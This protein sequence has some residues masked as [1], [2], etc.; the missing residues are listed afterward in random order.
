MKII[1]LVYSIFLILVASRP[2]QADLV[3][4]KVERTIELTSNVA[5]I[6]HVISVENKAASAVKSYLFVVEPEHAKILAYIGAKLSGS[7]EDTKRQLKISEQQGDKTKGSFYKIEFKEDLTPGSSIVLE[8]ELSLYEAMRP[9]PVEITQQEKQYVIFKGNHYYYSAY[10][11][12]GKQTTTVNL[13]SDRIESYSQLKPT[14]KS[15]STITY[16][17]YDAVPTFK[18]DE[19][20]VH[21]ENNAPFL[22]VEKLIRLIEVSHWGNIAVEETIDLVHNGAKLKGSFSRFDYMRRQGGSASVKSFKTLLPHSAADVYYRDEIG[23]I[24]TSNLKVPSKNNKF[25]PVE[26]ELRPRFPLF[27][28]WRTHYTIGYNI[29]VYQY[30]YNKGNDFVLKMKLIDHIIEDQ[31]IEDAQIRVIL[32]ERATDIEFVAPYTVE[33]KKNELHF[34][35][36]D[37]VGR[38][39]IVVNKKHAVEN[40]IEDFQIRYTYKKSVIYYK[41]LLLVGVLFLIFFLVILTVRIDFTIS[42]KPNDHL[43][44]E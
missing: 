34:T 37:T 30:L 23:N 17:P 43:K 15:D 35:Y 11:T 44:K 38:P 26:L 2:T 33:R 10:A 20:S 40:H 42:T 25:Q 8:V 13:A 5:H 14:S 3:N 41:P 6:N 31:Y 21:F 29:P 32:P 1:V 39:V 4:T 22:T 24:S 19:M 16:G 12:T 18:F 7:G 28:G 36:L 27:G 9:Y